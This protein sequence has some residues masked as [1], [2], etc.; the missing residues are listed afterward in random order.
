MIEIIHLRDKTQKEYGKLSLRFRRMIEICAFLTKNLCDDDLVVTSIYR[1]PPQ[2]P[3]KA[4]VHSFFRGIDFRIFEKSGEQGTYRIA[5]IMNSI[6]QYDHERPDMQVALTKLYHGTGPH[7][8]LQIHPNTHFLNQ[9]YK[10]RIEKELMAQR[11]NF[12]PKPIA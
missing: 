6:Y 7:L 9:E 1:M 10:K 2:P 4:G 11:E 3:K 5:E 12:D 8:H